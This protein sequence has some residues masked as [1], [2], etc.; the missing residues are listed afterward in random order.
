MTTYFQTIYIHYLLVGFRETP[1]TIEQISLI[2]EIGIMDLREH[3]VEEY[4]FIQVAIQN[5]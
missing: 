1:Y 4:Q 5:K 2:E 3:L